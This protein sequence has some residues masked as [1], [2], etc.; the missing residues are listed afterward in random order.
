VWCGVILY[1]LNTFYFKKI[2][3]LQHPLDTLRGVKPAL[4]PALPL[5]NKSQ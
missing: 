5:K 1:N 4:S 2:Q 3:G